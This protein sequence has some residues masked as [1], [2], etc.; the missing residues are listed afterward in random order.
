[1]IA[2][3]LPLS[4][5]WYAVALRSAFWRYRDA[6]NSTVWDNQGLAVPVT[7]FAGRNARRSPMPAAERAKARK[8]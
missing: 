6:K 4:S 8:S 5:N 2:A 7:P 3:T 1:M